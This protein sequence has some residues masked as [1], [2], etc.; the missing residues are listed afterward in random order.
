MAFDNPAQNLIVLEKYANKNT[1]KFTLED[2]VSVTGMPVIETEEAVSNM[3]EK[4]DC[5][6][7]VTE[8]GDLIYDFGD[9]LLRRHKKPWTEYIA[10]FFRLLWKGFTVCYKLI[11]SV[12]LVFYF[13][14]FLV[15]LI[16][17]AVGGKDNDGVGNLIGALLRVFISIF[18]WNTI[19][20]YNHRYYR[21]DSYGYS[22][23][24]YKEKPRIL[25][26]KKKPKNPKDEKN[27]IASIY[28][29]IFG[30]PRV[31]IDPLANNQEVAT[32]LREQ[33]GLV[34]TSEIQAL[35]GWTREEAENFM[36]ECLSMFNGQAHV[37]DNGTLY[38]DFSQLIRSKDRTG[39]EPVVWYWDEYEPEY[40]LTGNSEGRNGW[41]ILMNTFNLIFSLCLVFGGF[42]GPMGLGLGFWGS[43]FV[44]GF[45]LVYSSLFF[46]IPAF[47]WLRQRPLRRKQHEI[48]IR[49]RLM[50]IVYQTYDNGEKHVHEIPLKK[51]TEVANADRN[52]EEKLDYDT[53]ERIM[54]DTL[55]ELG[56]EA[57]L[58]EQNE[59]IYKF[60]LIAQE[61]DD[62]DTIRENKKEDSNLGNIIFES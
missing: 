56:G 1:K 24:H 31:E 49:K 17:I 55:S 57:Y 47:R 53:I 2:A 62:I 33:K 36:T 37:S 16:G 45:P 10:D 52:S 50:R 40:E 27:F 61:L 4:Y 34:T 19:M 46:L 6:L 8:N 15:L 41:I 48:N 35:A 22:Y 44:G 3:M 59:I 38:G 30:P 7:R 23:Q 54:K 32:F 58:N 12:I 5:K 11:T 28:D 21:T 51:L 25:G 26:T 13:V 14:F 42:L 39:E 43:F 9:D 18:E 29:F 20:G 60:D